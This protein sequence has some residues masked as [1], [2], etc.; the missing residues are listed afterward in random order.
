MKEK[1]KEVDPE[2]KSLEQA[3]GE[4]DDET[5]KKE[6]D[7]INSFIDESNEYEAKTQKG[8]SAEARE[9]KKLKMK[10]DKANKAKV[11][12]NNSM[13][14]KEFDNAIKYYKECV[15]LDPT[16]HIAFSNM[17]QAYIYKKSK[18]LVH[19]NSDL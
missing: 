8:D 6:I 13:Q 14:A 11:M 1:L 3:R 5:K 18:Y 10:K 2:F 19:S 9:A 15:E 7:M 12:G 17:A 4:V 16:H